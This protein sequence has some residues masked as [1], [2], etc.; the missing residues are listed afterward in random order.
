MKPGSSLPGASSISR[1]IPD[2]EKPQG[3]RVA[4]DSRVARLPRYQWALAR[5]ARDLR[6]RAACHHRAGK[7][8]A[9]SNARCAQPGAH[10]HQAQGELPQS[11]IVPAGISGIG[12]GKTGR[13]PI[14]KTAECG[15]AFPRRTSSFCFTF[16]SSSQHCSL[17]IDAQPAAPSPLEDMCEYTL[18]IHRSRGDFVMQRVRAVRN[19]NIAQRP[20]RNHTLFQMDGLI[21]AGNDQPKLPAGY[22]SVVM[23][24][25]AET[26][27]NNGESTSSS[28]YWSRSLTAVAQESSIFWNAC[29][30]GVSADVAV[31][32]TTGVSALLGIATNNSSKRQCKS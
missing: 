1:K 3:C 25:L 6:A 26:S 17:R 21:F 13:L 12:T 16:V 11:G 28:P 7:P 32:L 23:S 2:R 9:W 8:I 10:F 19:N 15:M 14:L 22:R 24:P 30:S 4:G 31:G 20:N 18:F 27:T 5:D 29:F